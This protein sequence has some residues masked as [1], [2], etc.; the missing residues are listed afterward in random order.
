MF[1]LPVDGPGIEIS[2]ICPRQLILSRCRGGGL[3]GIEEY[4]YTGTFEM[5]ANCTDWVAHFSSCCRNSAITNLN[6]TGGV[7]Q[8][9]EARIK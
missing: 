1:T 9:I 5:P 6:M 7:G 3:P 8:Y 4:T 2:P